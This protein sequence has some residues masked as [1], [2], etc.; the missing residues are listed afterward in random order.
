MNYSINSALSNFFIKNGII[1]INGISIVDIVNRYG[2]PI[3]IYDLNVIKKR[4]D[5]LRSEIP[6]KIEIYYAVKANP[7]KEVIQLISRLYDGFDVSS[8]GEIKKVLDC[9]ISPKI[10]NFTGPGKTKEEISYAIEIGIGSINIESERELHLIDLFCKDMKK[11]IGVMI[12]VNPDFDLRN[13]GMSMGGIAKQ[14]GID[15]ILVPNMIKYIENS[16]NIKFRGIHIYSGSQ[17]LDE[18]EL[19]NHFENIF[20]YAQSLCEKHKISLEILNIGGGFG[21]PYFSH[22]KP[23]NLALVG[24]GLKKLIDKYQK[25][26]LNTQFRIELGR[27]IIGEAGLY[28]SRILY[29][30]VSNGHTYII[31][32]GGMHH[33]LAA[34]GNLGQSLVRRPFPLTV[35]NKINE[36]LEDVQVVGCL[37]TPLDT[38]GLLK[39]PRSTENDLLAV[40]N[41][42]AYGYSA[43]PLFFL[44]HRFPVEVV[45]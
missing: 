14:F 7:N 35:A 8:M 41:S 22:E 32:D 45:I 44:S 16:K 20:K 40:L 11:N 43:S 4:H 29:R 25:K 37:C 5:Q 24:H 13:S 10:L 42:G 15:E 38:F 19:L 21:I 6:D 28:L 1:E 31:I 23:L 34:S 26:M 33:H 18:N 39:L 36:P 27:Y 30:K 17:I 2:T 3:Y 12:R 9:G